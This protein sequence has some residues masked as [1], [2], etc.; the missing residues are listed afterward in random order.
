MGESKNTGR[1]Q[2]KAAFEEKLFEEDP[3]LVTRNGLLLTL[4][5]GVQK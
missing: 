3:F 2:I 1:C 5:K 4:R